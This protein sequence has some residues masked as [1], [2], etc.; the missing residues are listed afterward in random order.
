M[1][2]QQFVKRLW[3]SLTR[4]SSSRSFPCRLSISLL[5]FSPYFPS[6]SHPGGG[7][8]RSSWKIPFSILLCSRTPDPVPRSNRARRSYSFIDS[9]ALSLPSWPRKYF[10]DKNAR[11]CFMALRARV[12]AR[13]YACSPA[14]VRSNGIDALYLRGWS[15]TPLR[16]WKR[17]VTSLAAILAKSVWRK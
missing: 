8:A 13:V 7:W 12:C 16:K 10:G 11:D 6:S 4:P 9:V 17:R 14:H 15:T 1:W 2:V 3:A 5:S